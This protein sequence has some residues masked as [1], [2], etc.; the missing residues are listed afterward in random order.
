MAAPFSITAVWTCSAPA[1]FSRR[2]W[3]RDFRLRIPLFFFGGPRIWI[4][5]RWIPSVGGG[6]VEQCGWEVF[7]A[8]MAAREPPV[9][10]WWWSISPSDSSPERSDSED[11]RIAF[12]RPGV[13]DE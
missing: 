12:E 7:P 11:H 2:D 6:S 8:S 10:A 1:N 5:G 9:V 3:R 13:E 4:W